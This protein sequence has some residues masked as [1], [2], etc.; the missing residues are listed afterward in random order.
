[1][2]IG[3]VVKSRNLKISNLKIFKINTNGASFEDFFFFF[4]SLEF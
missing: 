2:N 1:M 3:I 4:E